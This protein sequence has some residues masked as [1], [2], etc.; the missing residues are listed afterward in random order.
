[1]RA[2]FF[3]IRSVR[4]RKAKKVSTESEVP[5]ISS[6]TN[7]ND[8]EPD[9]E[10]DDFDDDEDP[11]ELPIQAIQTTTDEHG[12]HVLTSE[13]SPLAA[14]GCSVFGCLLWNGILSIFVNQW[15]TG[16]RAGQQQILF[17]V[18]LTP[19][20]LA[21]IATVALVAYTFLAIFNPRPIVAVSRTKIALG[22]PLEIFWRFSGKATSVQQ[23]EIT[24]DGSERATYRRGTSTYTDTERFARI[25]LKQ[26]D[27]SSEIE[28]GSV[29]INIPATTMHSFN[30]T[31]NKVLWALR[32]VGKIR[33][34][35][36]VEQ[37]FPITI[38][39]FL[40]SGEAP[41]DSI[42]SEET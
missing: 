1:M 23:L 24:L 39:P 17:T 26:T 9:D 37:T 27:Q 13:S 18:L 32:I 38:L 21:G 3:T 34:W 20:V 30:G 5:A 16:F 15:L 11:N 12:R 40:L 22:D 42:P 19:F 29:T 7:A 35:P 25:T 36:D 6:T 8:L 31:D 33:W 41:Q 10:E 4:S 2:V 28:S 14:F